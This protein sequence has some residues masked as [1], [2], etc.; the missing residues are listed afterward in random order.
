M[1][2]QNTRLGRQTGSDNMMGHLQS[3]GVQ[4]S[5]RMIEA[6]QATYEAS[7]EYGLSDEDMGRAIDAAIRQIGRR[8]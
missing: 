8:R 5:R 7:P 3:G 1:K 4:V 6:A 2:M